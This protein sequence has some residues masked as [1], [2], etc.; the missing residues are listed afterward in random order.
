MPNISAVRYKLS[1]LVHNDTITCKHAM[2][3]KKNV[4]VHTTIPWI[5]GF[6]EAVACTQVV[7]SDTRKPLNP[8]YTTTKTLFEDNNNDFKIARVQAQGKNSGLNLKLLTQAI[9]FRPI[10]YIYI[11]I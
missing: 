2:I 4:G 9:F 8:G 6:A 1:T 5:R 10:V 3:G 11:Y 7:N